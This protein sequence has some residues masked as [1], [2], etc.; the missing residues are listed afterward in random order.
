MA[1]LFSTPEQQS[2]MLRTIGVGSVSEL[3]DQIPAELRL[4]RDLKLPPPLTELELETHLQDL[5]SR[6]RGASGTVCFQGGGAYDH[7]IPAAV[8]AIASRSEFYTAYTPYQAE[9]SQGS[10]QAFFEFQSLIC[11]LTGMDVSNASL[12]EG[13]TAVSEAVFMAMR[14]TDRHSRI[15][16]LGSINPEYRSVVETYSRQVNCE[17]VVVDTPGGTADLKSVQA[18][19]NDQTACLVIQHPNYFG[20]LEEVEQLVAAAHHVGA[21]AIVSFDPLSLGLLKRPGEYGADI[22]V[23]EGQSLGIPLQYGGPFLG[24]LTCRNQFVRKMPGRLIGETTDRNGKRCFVLNLQAREQHIR[25]EK[26][27]S[28]ICTNQGLMALRATVYLSLLGPQGL[29]EVSELCCRKAHYAAQQLAQV[30]GLSLTFDRPF[31]K[32]F[33]LSCK[34]GSRT[35]QSRAA[36]AGFSIGPLDTTNPGN[37]LC[38]VTE[39][40]TRQEIDRLAKTLA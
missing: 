38:A 6:N 21:L 1:Y 15:V 32:E 37:L 26:A 17:V 25:R 19:L 28:N 30:P 36:D 14:S 10:L 40:R 34:S 2:A 8:D 11:G 24:I 9:A 35:V 29:R 20:A 5:A 4:N 23:A 16:A 33:S 27:T 22:A 7:F 12:Y 3:F 39:K 18:A 31:F 13:G